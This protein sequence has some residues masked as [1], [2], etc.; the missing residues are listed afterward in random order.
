MAAIVEALIAPSM[1]PSK[2]PASR[3]LRCRARRNSGLKSLEFFVH[4]LVGELIA[5]LQRA[6]HELGGLL[7]VPALHAFAAVEHRRQVVDA[8]RVAEVGGPPVEVDG[9]GVVLLDALA[10][11]VQIAEVDHA[12]GVAEVGRPLAPVCGL[13]GVDLHADAVVV[14]HGEVDHG[15]RMA[16]LAGLGE[17][18]HRLGDVLVDAPCR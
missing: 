16:G 11:L 18:A 15:R 6:Q 14:H 13:G 17:E 4:H 2:T 8:E 10:L 7:G 12:G 9:G 1:R 3:S 5:H